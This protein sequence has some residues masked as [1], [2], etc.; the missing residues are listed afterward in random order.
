MTRLVRFQDHDSKRFACIKL[1]SGAP[2]WVSIARTGVLVKR[3]K[4][5]LMGEILYKEKNVHEIAEKAKTLAKLYPDDV[6]PHNLADPVFRGFVNAILRCSDVI[7][8]MRVLN[9]TESLFPDQ[10]D[11]ADTPKTREEVRESFHE[12]VIEHERLRQPVIAEYGKVLS[13]RKGTIGKESDL[14][15]QKDTLQKALLAQI[16]QETNEDM[17]TAMESGYVELESFVSDG[18]YEKAASFDNIMNHADGRPPTPDEALATNLEGH[19][20]T[21]QFILANQERALAQ[22]QEM[23]KLKAE[24]A[25]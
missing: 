21:Q 25:A 20:E 19:Y 15:F 7:G 6:T 5:G 18:L 10:E 23:R 4:L 2:I 12:L 17:I 1:A 8:V 11:D 9:N 14:P 16:L 3:S 22:L 13:N 24:R